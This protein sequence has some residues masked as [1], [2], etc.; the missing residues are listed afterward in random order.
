MGGMGP[1]GMAVHSDEAPLLQGEEP[2]VPGLMDKPRVYYDA[3]GKVAPHAVGIITIEDVLEELLQE[4][5]V[6]E[7][8]RFVDNSQREAVDKRKLQSQLMPRLR[9]MM[10]DSDAS[11]RALEAV[12]EE[13]HEPAPAAERAEQRELRHVRPHHALS[14]R[15]AGEYLCHQL[16]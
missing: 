5:I 3:E 6:D 12:K 2:M 16:G 1:G 4:E 14:V 13:L 11:A 7:T 15:I 9:R 8:D 10:S